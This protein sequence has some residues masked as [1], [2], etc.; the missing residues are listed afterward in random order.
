MSETETRT[1]R[2]PEAALEV[3]ISGNGEPVVL[4]QTALV[5]DEFLPLAD[6]LQ[7]RL[8]DVQVIRYYRRGYKGSSRVAGHGSIERDAEDCEQLLT[9][10]DVG[11]ANIVGVSYS[12]AVAMQLAA[13]APACVRSLCLIEPPPV[14]VPSADDFLAANQELLATYRR[15]GSSAALDEFMAVVVGAD[16]RP[17]IERLVAGAVAQIEQDADTF[18]STDIPALLDWEFGPV[19]ASP[20][21]QPVLYV[22]GTNSGPWFTEVRDLVL[23]WLPQAED[24]MVEGADHF[25]VLTHPAQVGEAVTTFLYR[26]RVEA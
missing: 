20:V 13:A 1:V 9:A 3:A 18:F 25:V 10:L 2:L 11:P 6:E 8:N 21:N 15:H 5:A 22:G 7:R 16:W 4:I 14:H 24:V 12:G 19:D 17:Q 23:A 26:H